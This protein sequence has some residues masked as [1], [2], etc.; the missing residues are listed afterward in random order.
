MPWTV[1]D[2]FQGV[3]HANTPE[4]IVIDIWDRNENRVTPPPCFVSP[5]PTGTTG[6]P[7]EVNV[8][9]LYQGSTPS[10]PAVNNRNNVAYSTTTFD[11]GWVKIEFCN[12]LTGT[13]NGA[14]YVGLGKFFNFGTF[15]SEYEGLPLL[16]LSLQEY[17]NNSVGGWYGD[18][19]PAWYELEWEGRIFP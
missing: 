9:G 2:S 1:S 4:A 5:C 16:A 8:I 15:Y 12:V 11:S 18:I 6:L 17:S 13:C 3:H 19:R 14:T 7:Y 10:V